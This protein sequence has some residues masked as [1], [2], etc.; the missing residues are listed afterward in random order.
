MEGVCGK[1][2]MEEKEVPGN[3]SRKN[4]GWRRDDDVGKKGWDGR[5]G[6]NA[7]VGGCRGRKGSFLG[8]AVQPV[9]PTRR[10]GGRL[11]GH[12]LKTR[13]IC[14][15]AFSLPNNWSGGGSGPASKCRDGVPPGVS[16]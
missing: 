3:G 4:A 12:P 7:R 15:L 16:R 1:K 11:R 10:E 14:L 13:N 9:C 2:R 6:I 8:A 5:D